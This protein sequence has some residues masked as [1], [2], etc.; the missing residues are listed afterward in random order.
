MIDGDGRSWPRKVF[1]VW[2]GYDSSMGLAF[3]ACA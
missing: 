1:E 3:D 2:K